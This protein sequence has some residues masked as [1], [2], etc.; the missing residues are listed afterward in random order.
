M[1]KDI[2]NCLGKDSSMLSLS[3]R[4][5]LVSY[6]WKYLARVEVAKGKGGR[7]QKGAAQKGGAQG[8]C[9]RLVAH[10]E[11]ALGRRA[12]PHASDGVV[13]GEAEA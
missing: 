10:L 11:H 9:A 4:E 5:A 7:S 12:G 1:L 3:R 13:I 8:R 6:S 2:A